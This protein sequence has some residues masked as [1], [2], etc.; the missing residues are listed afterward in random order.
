MQAFILNY[1]VGECDTTKRTLRS[2]ILF[3]PGKGLILFI[4][5]LHACFIFT[6]SY[7]DLFIVFI[8]QVAVE[9]PAKGSVITW[10]FDILKGDVTFTVL[11]CCNPLKTSPHE[12]HVSGAVGGIG[13]TQYTDKHWTV[14][15]DV[16]LVEPPVVCRDGDSIQVWRFTC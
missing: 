11:R 6:S 9:V 2:G 5:Y 15:I 8:V 12:H 14:G 10:D 16:S 7:C 13:S 1:N 4:S 3:S